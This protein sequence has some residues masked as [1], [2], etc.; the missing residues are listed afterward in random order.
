MT[1]G[2]Q[3]A[4]LFWA[5]HYKVPPDLIEA[6]IQ[7]ES[8]G[9]RCAMRYEPNYQWLYQPYDV[10]PKT[11]TRETEETGQKF[12][13]G[14][15]QVMG[16]TARELGY[17][18]WLSDLCGP[19]GVQYGVKYLNQLYSKYGDWTDVVAA[20]NAGKPRKAA[21]GSYVNQGYVDKVMG[22]WSS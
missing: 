20:Y 16:G 21:D 8:G 15:M 4:V 17:R 19:K 18:G 7:I 22:V 12:S 9:D 14:P 13:Y 2:L 11:S 10:K 3:L 6:I 5:M 1:Q